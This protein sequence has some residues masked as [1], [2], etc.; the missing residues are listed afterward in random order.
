MFLRRAM[1]AA[2]DLRPNTVDEVLK[3]EWL[4]SLEGE[5]AETLQVEIPAWRWP[6]D[7]ELI[8]PPP[9]D[10]VYIYW[11]C[12]MIDWAQLDMQLYQ[13][14]MAMFEAAKTSAIAW[15]RR[16]HVPLVNEKGARVT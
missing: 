5:L 8:L 3:S 14:D 7:Q 15:W 4:Y 12:A 9:G 16:H 1:A 2:D 6:E 13:V 10:M 11:L